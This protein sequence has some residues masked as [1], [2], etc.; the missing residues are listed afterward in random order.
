LLPRSPEIDDGAA[1]L[2]DAIAAI[3]LSRH[4]VIAVGVQVHRHIDLWKHRGKLVLVLAS[5]S[6]V[7]EAT[8]E[9]IN[10]EWKSMQRLVEHHHGLWPQKA[11]EEVSAFSFDKSSDT[12][13]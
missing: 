8:V 12:E 2:V 7:P 1:R 9:H 4:E 11:K 5:N 6:D 3:S 13:G 10:V